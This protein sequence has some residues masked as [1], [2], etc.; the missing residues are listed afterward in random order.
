[1]ADMYVA[2]GT[3]TTWRRTVVLIGRRLPLECRYVARDV[4]HSLR[5]TAAPTRASR[6]TSCPRLKPSSGQLATDARS[7]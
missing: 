5:G 4:F 3:V 7:Q 1:M 2:G 6:E